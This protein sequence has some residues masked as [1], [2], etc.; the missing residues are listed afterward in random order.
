[1]EGRQST[2]E[3]KHQVKKRYPAL[4]GRAVTREER[5]RPAELR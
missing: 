2:E 3:V 1:M 5:E 4:L